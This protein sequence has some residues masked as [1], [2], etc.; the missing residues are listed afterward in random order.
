MTAKAE[1]IA[2][3]KADVSF[4]C[5][6]KCEIEGLNIWVVSE[7]VYCWRYNTIFYCENSRNGLDTASGA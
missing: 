6:V 5:F 2:Q 7:M 1:C 3:C 4:H